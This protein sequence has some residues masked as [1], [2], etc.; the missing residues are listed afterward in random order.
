MKA[1]ADAKE[2]HRARLTLQSLIEKRDKVRLTG[3]FSPLPSALSHLLFKI[4]EFEFYNERPGQRLFVGRSL[5]KALKA[6]GKVAVDG[7]HL[8]TELIW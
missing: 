7:L 5:N 1:N 6:L 8:A 2:P 3:A 4:R